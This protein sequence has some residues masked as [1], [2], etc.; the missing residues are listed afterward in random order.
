M[1]LLGFFFLV[2]V[3]YGWWQSG[4]YSERRLLYFGSRSAEVFSSSSLIRVSVVDGYID[5]HGRSRG[6]RQRNA[7]GKMMIRPLAPTLRMAPSI[8]EIIF[9]YWHLAVVVFTGMLLALILE[10]QACLRQWRLSRAGA[11]GRN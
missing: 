3:L 11:T 6:Y 1:S 8:R 10:G 7:R 4:R 9:G 2:L 5:P